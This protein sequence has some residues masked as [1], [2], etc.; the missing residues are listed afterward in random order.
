MIGQKGIKLMYILHCLLGLSYLKAI[1][2]GN[3]RQVLIWNGTAQ[4]LNI[5]YIFIIIYRI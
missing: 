5:I 1:P 4:I 2:V 3:R